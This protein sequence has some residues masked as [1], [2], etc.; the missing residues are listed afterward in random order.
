[1]GCTRNQ[2]EGDDHKLLT[3]MNTNTEAGLVEL[4]VTFRALDAGRSITDRVPALFAEAWPAYRSWFLQEGEA[5][6]PSYATGLRMLR[7]HMPELVATYSQL[8]ESVGGGDLEARFLSHWSPPPLF[9]N[10]SLAAWTGD[11]NVLVHNYD[12]SPLLCDAAVL[13][14][15]WHG[16]GVMAMSDCA[17][18]AT[19]GMNEH[20]LA[21]AIAFGG[22]TAVGEGFGVGLIIRYVLEFATDIGSALEIL[23]HVPVRL[24]YNVALVDRSGR[25]AIA[26]IAPDRQLVVSARQ[27]AANRQGETEWPEH[28]L[29]CAT[30]EREAALQAAVAEPSMTAAALVERFLAPPVYRYPAM[31][32]WGT[33]YTVAYDCDRTTMQL[34]WPGE[35]WSLS[36]ANFVEGSV[37]RHTEAMVPLARTDP[38]VPPG[39]RPLLIA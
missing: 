24:S 12:Y 1:V 25:G 34:A 32:P 26:Q 20:G 9:G 5:A 36:M 27:V 15:S 11:E 6:R 31:T 38:P 17:W 16:A 22:R 7:R 3:D 14:S 35:R 8:V 2:T 10:C 39:Y 30:E 28:S 23:R 33:V 4:D 37:T 29:F 19:D 18:G 21:A 13:R